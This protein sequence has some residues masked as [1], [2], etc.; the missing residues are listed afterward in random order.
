MGKIKFGLVAAVLL[1]SVSGSAL[2][3]E[4]G[5]FYGAVDVGQSKAKDACTD[6]FPGETCT[7]TGTVLR[8]AVGYQAHP[9][10]AVEA[11]Y[12][13]Y[14]KIM[15]F[16]DN[17]GGTAEVKASG[18]QFS[19]VG[20]WPLAD[21][22]SVTGKL[23]LALT[24]GEIAA[25]VVGVGSYAQDDSNTTFAW[26]VGAHFNINQSVAIRAQY[27][28]LGEISADKTNLGGRD[29]DLLSAGVVFSF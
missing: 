10:V 18:F 15:E 3:I 11:S 20:S 21:A 28:R 16:N 1:A 24:K 5:Q 17:A 26:G 25:R 9:N 19:A 27:E 23:G 13:N 22:F 7:D 6:V 12:A 8:G 14:G 29:L 4:V 2:A